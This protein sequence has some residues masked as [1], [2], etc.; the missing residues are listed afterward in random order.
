MWNPP[1]AETS[2]DQ[3]NTGFGVWGWGCLRILIYIYTHACVYIH[4]YIHTYMQACKHK[5][6]MQNKHTSKQASKQAY[7]YIHTYIHTYTYLHTYIYV[8]LLMGLHSFDYVFNCLS[9]PFLLQFRYHYRPFCSLSLSLARSLARA[10]FG[11]DWLSMCRTRPLHWG[12]SILGGVARQQLQE[13]D[14]DIWVSA[15]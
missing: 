1:R 13:K 14:K 8:S 15:G 12:R 2:V 3:I 5:Q 10:A 4:R 6:H 9:R 11:L 7:C